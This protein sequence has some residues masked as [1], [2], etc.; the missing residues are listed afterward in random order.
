MNPKQSELN[1]FIATLARNNFKG[2]KIHQ[3]LV[4]SWGAE[5]TVCVRRVQQ[6]KK[7]YDEEDRELHQR[8]TGSGRQR[9]STSDGNI[10][11]VKNLIE[12]NN[13]LSCAAI[14]RLTGI[15][16]TAVWRIITKKLM[17][18]SLFCRWVPHIL[19]NS[20]KEN[21]V[22]CCQAMIEAFSRRSAKEKI[23]V[24]DEKWVY[25]RNVPPKECKRA[26]VDGAGD[27]PVMARRT[28]SDKKFM[29]IVAMNY[30]KS[31][32]YFEVLEDGGSINAERY[33]VFLQRMRAEFMHKLLPWEMILQHDNARPHVAHLVH[34]WLEQQHISLLKQ[35]PY[36]PD[37]NLMDRFIF[38]NYESF[39]RDKN[40]ND[41]NAMR[42]SVMEFLNSI[43]SAKLS[44]EFEKVK[45]HLN[46]VILA[47]GDYI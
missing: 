23:I 43:T 33:L 1:F 38:R 40:F 6:I 22:T 25:L 18:K 3:M 7:E 20:H 11:I 17:K 34:D 5:N 41:S 32:V 35:A 21:R 28:I 15:E 19:L 16:E 26:W 29:I 13:Q 42:E 46:S 4:D 36:S 30:A 8:K 14:E 44:K 45:V 39:R 37:T 24:I 31:L 9:T 10:D 12:N 2:T 47:R 27:R